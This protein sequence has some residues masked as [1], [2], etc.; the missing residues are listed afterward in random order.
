M[1]QFL[2]NPNVTI[3]AIDAA[4][5]GIVAS[6]TAGELPAFVQ[7]SASGITAT[8]TSAPYEDLEYSW[9]FGDPSGI[10]VFT[11]PVT[12]ASVNA[13]KTQKGPE[14]AYCY[15][16][17]GTFT[18]TLTVRGS[19][20]AP[21]AG[22]YTQF[23]T[24][25]ATKTFTASAF[26]TSGGEYWFNS[27][28]GLDA[29]TGLD[30]AH[31][32]QTLSAL[33][34]L[35]AASHMRFHLARGSNWFGSTGIY[36]Q[37]SDIRI[38]AY[39]TGANPIVNI[40]NAASNSGA[41]SGFNALSADNTSRAG[42]NLVVSNV[43]FWRSGTSPNAIVNLLYLT[44]PSN[45]S[46]DVYLDNV[47]IVSDSSS[48]VNS[49][50]M[51]FQWN[52]SPP[53]DATN[54]QNH[55]MWGG[56]LSQTIA[57][58]GGEIGYFG[59]AR[60]WNFF[61]GISQISGSG[62]VGQTNLC[63]HI[64]PSF[65]F[66][67]LFRWI[68]FGSGPNRNYCINSNWD[69]ASGSY[70]LGGYWLIAEN[71]MTGVQNG[72]DASNG[73]GTHAGLSDLTNFVVERNAFHDLTQYAALFSNCTS[74]TWRY[75]NIWN[76]NAGLVAVNSDILSTAELAIAMKIYGN[77]IYRNNSGGQTSGTSPLCQKVVALT[78]TA[79]WSNGSGSSGTVL[80]MVTANQVLGPV[81]N[82]QMAL[83]ADVLSPGNGI[84]TSFGTGTGGTGTYNLSQ[85]YLINSANSVQLV[86]GWTA[87]WTI[88]DNVVMDISAT[89]A[90]MDLQFTN[91][92]TAKVNRNQWYCPNGNLTPGN[93]T[94]TPFFNNRFAQTFA[95]LKAAGFGASDT[96]VDPTASYPY[97]VNPANGQFSN[98]RRMIVKT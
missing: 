76:M 89:P 97:W 20:A 26:S 27:I 98:K 66:H 31:P 49:K 62:T 5:T 67:G 54:V 15:R 53:A 50:W 77:N 92:S 69:S 13:N 32:K 8:G 79:T 65:Q 9:D 52:A 23:T 51:R 7:V 18:I 75:N 74:M 28:T 16:A 36:V 94:G 10:E 1:G 61:V 55:G 82:G 70:Q 22:V 84:I 64:Y 6:R 56:S 25:T 42:G 96:V 21:I 72:H 38:D 47:N 3:T 43:D 87:P 34:T 83:F 86:N 44:S 39:G 30:S 85:P 88:T 35:L 33:N 17:A 29:N 95:Q 2:G 71:N 46:N 19:K 73:G 78:G 60:N 45:T 57:N 14:A 90:L 48:T 63:H 4:T 58:Q 81:T 12:G 24:A 59:G 68:N 11:N 80:N 93:Q 37:Y 91:Q 41:G 40:H